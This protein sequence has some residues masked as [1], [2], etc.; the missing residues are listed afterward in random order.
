[1]EAVGNH[2]SRGPVASGEQAKVAGEELMVSRDWML[3]GVLEA[4]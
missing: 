2:G 4:D 3:P 1:M